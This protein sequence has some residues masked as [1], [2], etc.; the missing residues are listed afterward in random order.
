ML[1]SLAGLQYLYECNSCTPGMYCPNYGMTA[2]AGNCSARYYCAE[3]A[4]TATPTDGSTGNK[5]PVGHYCPEGSP[6]PIQCE[7]GTYT[8]TKLNEVCLTCTAGY[9]C[10]M[11]SNPQACPAG[12]YCPD[13]T[14]HV[15]QSCPAGT[16]SGTTGLSN[17]TE[18]TQCTGGYYCD[19]KNLTTEAGQCD[20]GYYCR[21]GSDDRAPS[22][23]TAGDAGPCPVG[24]YC[25]VQTQEP[26]PCPA[27]TF[28]NQTKVTSEADCQPCSP[29]YYCD[30]PG[31]VYPAGLCNPGF[32]C[33]SGSN[34]SSPSSTD[35]TGGPCPAGT[36]CPMG[37]S[38][39]INC[40]AGTY[41]LT[42]QQSNCTTCPMGS[43]C[44]TGAGVLTP[45]P[46]GKFIFVEN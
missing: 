41:T 11:G 38:V 21:S 17:V 5:C 34:S 39:A 10:T 9:Y 31:L 8:D 42:S 24:H 19:V 16:F 1:R 35:A 45:C 27:G 37:T 40:Q 14:G 29:G 46:A 3:N 22:G 32:F 44:P 2:P 33:T 7:P 6:A 36:Y 15:W 26:T 43:Y 20:A 4:T 30:I 13:G 12:Y 23:A 28:N 18:C 25:T